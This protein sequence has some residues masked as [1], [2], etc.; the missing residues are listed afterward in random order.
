MQPR[1]ALHN[2]RVS[3][4]SPHG[5]GVQ[6]AGSFTQQP[7]V[8]AELGVVCGTG[9]S[10]VVACV[11]LSVCHFLLLLGLCV[12]RLVRSAAVQA[13]GVCRFG[14]WPCSAVWQVASLGSMLCMC[15]LA[16]GQGIDLSGN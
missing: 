11:V 12:H 16:A 1:G 15:S 10:A 6:Q 5:L 3:S 8:R 13:A 4:L 14:Q 9:M 2:A 7:M